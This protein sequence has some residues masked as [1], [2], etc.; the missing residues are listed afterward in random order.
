[1]ELI[2]ETA[3]SYGEKNT[4][5][6]ACTK[7]ETDKGIKYSY[8]NELGESKIFLMEDRIQIMR[9]GTVSGNQVFKL[10]EDTKFAYRTPYL[11]KNFILKTETLK[12]EE[13]RIEL[14]YSLYEEQERI[15]QIRLIIREA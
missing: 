10:G 11:M 9:K 1:M 5:R 2:I 8:E 7:E 4:E 15:N 14:L 3:D 13:G 6:V 12:R